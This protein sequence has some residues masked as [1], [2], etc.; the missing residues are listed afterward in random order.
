MN[1]RNV[2]IIGDTHFPFERKGYLAFTKAIQKKYKCG[3][4]LHIGDEVDNHAISQHIADPDGY[5][6][7]SE[8]GRALRSMKQWY[9]AYPNMHVCIGNHTNRPFRMARE[10]GLSAK[11]IKSY[12]SMWDAPKGWVWAD[13]WDLFGVHYTHGNGSSGPN[14]ALKRA[15]NLRKSVVIGHIHTEASIQ[16]NVSSIDAIFGMIVGCGVDDKAYAFHYAKDQPKKSI[17]SCGVVLDGNLPILELM[18]L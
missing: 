10:V 5:S 17:I 6:S 4:I 13:S 9:K 12:E 18:P 2:L 1:K 11:F 15:M 14:A 7:G 8:Y 3:T 16:Y